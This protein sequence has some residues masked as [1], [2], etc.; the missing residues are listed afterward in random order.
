MRIAGE[1]STSVTVSEAVH[2]FR[3]LS[4]VEQEKLVGCIRVL[5]RAPDI[6]EVRQLLEDR[7]RY[8]TRQQFSGGLCDRLE[9]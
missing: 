3:A 1:A 5:D 4:P 8:S 6:I 2:D 9:G 7:L